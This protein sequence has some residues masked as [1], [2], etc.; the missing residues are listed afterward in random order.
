M[1]E[2]DHAHPPPNCPIDTE[3]SLVIVCVDFI[4]GKCSRETCKYFHPPEHLVSQLKKQKI[5]NNAQVAAINAALNVNFIP[6]AL[7]PAN[8]TQY[9]GLNQNQVQ[10][11]HPT[12]IDSLHHHQLQMQQASSNFRMYPQGSASFNRHYGNN[13]NNSQNSANLNALSAFNNA[14]NVIPSTFNY[15]PVNLNHLNLKSHKQATNDL[16]ANRNQASNNNSNNALIS[17]ALASSSAGVNLVGLN[18]KRK[19]NDNQNTPITTLICTK[20]KFFFLL[21]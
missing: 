3:N 21:P 12:G 10:F 2:C 16:N 14:I 5:S 8:Y 19:K 7:S 17:A 1:N 6:Q 15:Q 9:L 13:N 18:L 20:L 4:K 11:H